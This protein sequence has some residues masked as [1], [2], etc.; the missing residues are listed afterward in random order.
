[1]SNCTATDFG[2]LEGALEPPALTDSE[3]IEYL[4]F[5]FGNDEIPGILPPTLG[6]LTTIMLRHL[7]C[8]PCNNIEMHYSPSHMITMSLPHIFDKVV[9]R[10]RGGWS[11]ELNTL[12]TAL[13]AA[14]GYTVWMAPARVAL[15][16]WYKPSTGAMRGFFGAIHCVN[17]V[18]FCD[19]ETGK[20]QIYL[21]DI[22]Y[23][24]KNILAPIPL[25]RSAF[26]GDPYPGVFEESHR[27]IRISPPQCRRAQLHWLLQYRS[28]D[29]EP[30]QDLYTFQESEM[31]F[32]DCEISSWWLNTRQMMV[33]DNVV[34]T[35]IVRVGDEAVGKL[36]LINGSLTHL[37]ES[38]AAGEYEVVEQVTE[39]VSEK[40]RVK[41]L[42]KKFGIKLSPKEKKAIRGWPT[43]LLESQ[44]DCGGRSGVDAHAGRRLQ[45]TWT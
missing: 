27:L 30:W 40:K 9:R 42:S 20:P 28:K 38:S 43:E 3:V 19:A 13:L 36:I 45:F 6:N 7:S 10:E 15:S 2:Y 23:G 26:D 11:M 24:H 39:L 31:T 18:E 29:G 32:G 44:S 14:L 8:V 16:Q 12:F 4:R 21:A 41:S 5:L 22:G 1:M 33:V 35:R 17:L 34:S 25:V 37:H